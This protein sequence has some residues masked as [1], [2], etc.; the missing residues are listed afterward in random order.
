M[1]KENTEVEKTSIELEIHELLDEINAI[2][3]DH[4]ADSSYSDWDGTREEC[5]KAIKAFLEKLKKDVDFEDFWEYLLERTK[6]RDEW[7]LD[8][9]L[10]DELEK[11]KGAQK[12]PKYGSKQLFFQTVY[13]RKVC[14]G[15]YATCEKCDHDWLFDTKG[16][17]TAEDID[18]KIERLKEG[19]KEA[20]E[21]IEELKSVKKDLRKIIEDGEEIA[22][23]EGDP[24]PKKRMKFPKKPS[25]EEFYKLER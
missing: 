6:D 7:W 3:Y 13:K 17:T 24:K 4:G 18:K 25:D 16:R 10:E 14:I 8:N 1:E 22:R 23:K 9:W 21:E 2:E 5:E 19:T 12:C 20:K 15:K 11:Y